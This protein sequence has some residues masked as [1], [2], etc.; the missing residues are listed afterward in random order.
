MIT[1]EPFL[2]I[3]GKVQ[4]SENVVLIRAENVE[5]LP[6]EELIGSESHDFH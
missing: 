3:E 6:H 1:Q 4:N 5:R 2:I